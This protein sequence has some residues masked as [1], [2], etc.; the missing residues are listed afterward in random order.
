MARG[1]RIRIT[2]STSGILRLSIEYATRDGRPWV[3]AGGTKTVCQLADA[4]GTVLAEMRGAGAHLQSVGEPGVEAV[5]RDLINR[6]LDKCGRPQIAAMCLGMAG[7]DQ[8]V[9]ADIVRRIMERIGQHSRALVVN[10]ALI[11]L[12]AGAPRRQASS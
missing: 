2:Q 9:E 5:L 3:D 6:A 10:D 1:A 11:A 7:V 4:T 12:E 8:P